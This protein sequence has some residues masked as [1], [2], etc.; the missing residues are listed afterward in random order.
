MKLYLCQIF[1]L[2]RGHLHVFLHFFFT[3]IENLFKKHPIQLRFT[4]ITVTLSLSLSLSQV[5]QES[6]NNTA[7]NYRVL[8][9]VI[10]MFELS[11]FDG[12]R[13]ATTAVS[14]WLHR[15][16]KSASNDGRMRRHLHFKNT[17]IG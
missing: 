2:L 6:S 10:A 4:Y 5:H 8:I 15:Q 14:R 16:K 12:R 7:E 11:G 3:F 9:T 13:S 17:G 1:V